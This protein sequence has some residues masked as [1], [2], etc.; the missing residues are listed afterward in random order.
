MA[1]N[2]LQRGVEWGWFIQGD[3]VVIL[4]DD[5]HSIA[6]S[7]SKIIFHNGNVLLTED[8]YYKSTTIQSTT[9]DESIQSLLSKASLIFAY[10]TVFETNSGTTIQ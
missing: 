2:S 5:E 10:S 4:I 8:P 1:V 3:D 7:S 9:Q 6:D